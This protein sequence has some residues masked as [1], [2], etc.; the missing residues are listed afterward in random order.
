[1]CIRDRSQYSV[2]ELKLVG[3]NYAIEKNAHYF[4][5]REFRVSLSRQ[6]LGLV[7]VIDC[8]I[9]LGLAI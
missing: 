1:M 6:V 2:T 3:I 7:L 9:A 8:L 5:N 4:L